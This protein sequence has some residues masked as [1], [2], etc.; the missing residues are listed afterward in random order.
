L[1]R[2]SRLLLRL[3]LAVGAALAVVVTMAVLAVAL[4]AALAMAVAGLGVKGLLLLGCQ[5]G[6]ERDR[7][8]R[9]S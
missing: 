5:R 4:H 7:C 2:C 9:A 8:V 6:V 3:H 1:R